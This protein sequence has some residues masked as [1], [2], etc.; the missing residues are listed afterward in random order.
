MT[1]RDRL[2][3]AQQGGN[4]TVADLARW[5]RRPDPTVRGWIQKGVRP[6]GGPLDIEDTEKWLFVLERLIAHG[7]GFPI[8]G[9]TPRQKIARLESIR[10]KVK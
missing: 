2:K 1:F 3:K 6:A 4:L 10:A 7:K 8:Q 9:L 5:F